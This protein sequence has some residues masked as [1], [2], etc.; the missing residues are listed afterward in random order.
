MDEDVVF[1]DRLG[2]WANQPTVVDTLHVSDTTLAS[3]RASRE[4]LAVDFGGELY[5]PLGEFLNGSV[6]AGLGLVLNALSA[7]F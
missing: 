3:M 6:V 1:Y 2:P 5:Y 7:G 4:L